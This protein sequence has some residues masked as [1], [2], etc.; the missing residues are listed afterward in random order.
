MK[1]IKSFTLAAFILIANAGLSAQTV[2]KGS[3]LLDLSMG[4]VG[5]ANSFSNSTSQFGVFTG[6]IEHLFTDKVGIGLIYNREKLKKNTI[7]PPPNQ[8]YLEY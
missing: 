7:I 6:K 8:T 3:N 4:G 2:K 1:P 5:I